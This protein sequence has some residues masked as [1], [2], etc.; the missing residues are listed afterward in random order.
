MYKKLLL[1]SLFAIVLMLD[2]PLYRD[3]LCRIVRLDIQMACLHHPILSAKAQNSESNMRHCVAM[4]HCRAF[5]IFKVFAQSKF[6]PFILPYQSAL[7]QV[8]LVSN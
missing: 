1:C 4:T 8:N 6:S 3:K 5:E 2:C 7:F